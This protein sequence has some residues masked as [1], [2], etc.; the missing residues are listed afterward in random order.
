[1]DEARNVG[2]AAGNRKEEIARL[3]RAAVDRKTSDLNGRRL[4]LDH[5]IVAE[6]VAKSHGLPVRPARIAPVR[7]Y[8]VVF[9]AARIRRSDGGRSKRGSMPSSGA[10]REIT[11]P[12][13]GTAFHP[14]VMKP[15]VSFND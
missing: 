15:Y 11:L 6:E 2:L 5:S 9:D 14:E 4:R 8:W 13:V 3:D 7:D 10:I 1:M 12:P